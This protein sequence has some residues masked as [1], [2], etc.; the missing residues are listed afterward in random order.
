MGK[1][2]TTVVCL[3]GLFLGGPARADAEPSA[4]IDA[5]LKGLVSGQTSAAFDALMG[6]SRID[7]LKPREVALV[8]GQIQQ[9]I[10]LYGQPSGYES[11]ARKPYGSSVVRLI[12]V[13]KH[14]DLALVWNFYF[15]RTANGWQLLNFD[16]NDQF[17]KLE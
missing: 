16:F 4:I 14:S 15:Y 3:V 11:V 6:H 2:V 17:Q 5:Y 9:G 8:K 13:T 1:L 7:E 12:Y 10:S